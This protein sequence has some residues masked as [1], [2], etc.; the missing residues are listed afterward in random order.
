MSST[1]SKDRAGLCSFTFANGHRCRT[2]RSASHPHLCYDHARK[3]AQARAVDQIGRDISYFFSGRY[4]SACDLSVA[5]AR[6]ISAVASAELK[7]RTASTLAYL[8]Q[9]LLQ[10]IHLAQHEYINA[11]GTNS[12]R[13]AVC[14]SVNDNANHRNPPA[15]QPL[16]AAQQLPGPS[17]PGTAQL[18]PQS[19]PV[20]A[21]LAQQPP[22]PRQSNSNPPALQSSLHGPSS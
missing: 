14:S 3:E 18:H 9:T 19:A 8:A 20:Q 2:P 7:P 4:L 6:L 22:P 5:L 17:Q 11:F 16:S 21:P 15:P 13:D 12:W 10:T 1:R